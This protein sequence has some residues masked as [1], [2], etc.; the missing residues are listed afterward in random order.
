MNIVL[1]PAYAKAFILPGLARPE[2]ITARPSNTF[3]YSEN[4]INGSI[5]GDSVENA[6]REQFVAEKLKLMSLDEKV[7]RMFIWKAEGKNMSKAYQ[8]RLRDLQPGGVIL[9]GD[10]VSD[11]LGRFTSE[12]QQIGGE[13]PFFVAID[14]EGGIVKRIKTDPNPGPPALSNLPE[15]EACAIHRRTAEILKTQG[16]NTNFGLMGD[17]AWSGDSYISKRSFGNSPHVVSIKV[18]KAIM[19]SSPILTTIKHYPGH[20]RTNVNSHLAVPEINISYEEWKNTDAVP[21]KTSINH[22]VDFVMTGH[23]KIPQIDDKPASLSKKH[24]TNLREMGFKGVVIT[25]DMMMLHAAGVDPKYA[26]IEALKAG[27]DQILYVGSP[28]PQEQLIEMALVLVKSGEI[29]E[30]RID[31]SMKRV[32]ATK[33]RMLNNF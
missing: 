17:I 33:F 7:R 3:D 5:S 25:D 15:N 6:L 30:E 26:L 18:E 13:V 20:G 31:E 27:N 29:S 24:I 16:I 32:L 10:N 14:Q 8:D 2:L 28:I 22:G 21:F 11:E 4:I 1:V 12:I 23:L 19:C 9:M